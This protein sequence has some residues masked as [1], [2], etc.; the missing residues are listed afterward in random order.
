MTTYSHRLRLICCAKVV[1]LGVGLLRSC[2]KP[3]AETSDPKAELLNSL[4]GV[5]VSGFEFSTKEDDTSA[6]AAFTN[7]A[8]RNLITFEKDT[9]NVV[10]QYRASQR[11]EGK[12]YEDVQN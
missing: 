6:I 2:S 11:Q 5:N 1:L 8:V 9:N 3:V 7:S 4:K 10:L 12:H